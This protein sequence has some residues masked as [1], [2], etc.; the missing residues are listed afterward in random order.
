MDGA[1]AYKYGGQYY[2]KME[3]YGKIPVNRSNLVNEVDFVQFDTDVIMPKDRVKMPDGNFYRVDGH[4]LER[5]LDI[6]CHY[7]YIPLFEIND[8]EKVTRDDEYFYCDYCK[9]FENKTLYRGTFD[10][11]RMCGYAY[12]CYYG[13]CSVCGE[14]HVKDD[15]EIT[16]DGEYICEECATTQG[17]ERCPNCGNHFI[18]DSVDNNEG[19]CQRC[20]NERF[21]GTILDYCHTRAESFFDVDNDG[22]V[23]ISPCECDKPIPMYL[24]IELEV[25]NEGVLCH[26]EL[27]YR[28]LGHLNVFDSMFCETKGDSSIGG[29]FELVTQPSTPKF[30]MSKPNW[31]DAFN[32]IMKNGGLS[33]DCDTCGLHMHVNRS[34]FKDDREAMTSLTVAVSNL[35]D[36]IVKFSR[37]DISEI[38]EWCKKVNIG[39]NDKIEDIEEKYSFDRYLAVNG[40]NTH[41]I[42]FRFFKGTLIYEQFIASIQMISMLVEYVRDNSFEIVRKASWKDIFGN[43]PFA[44][45]TAVCGDLGIDWDLKSPFENE[46]LQDPVMSPQGYDFLDGVGKPLFKLGHFTNRN[47]VMHCPSEEKANIFLAILHKDGRKWP[48]IGTYET[49]NRYRFYGERTCYA[50]NKGTYAPI[51]FYSNNGCPVLEFDDFSWLEPFNIYHYDGY[52]AMRV[53]NRAEDLRFRQYLDSVGQ[54]WADGSSYLDLTYYPG[55]SD[56]VYKFNENVMSILPLCSNYTVLNFSDFLWDDIEESEDDE[57]SEYHTISF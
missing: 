23:T 33:H 47:F 44:E 10:G 50:F 17:W 46:P 28:T 4:S 24:G 3:K 38:D 45:F 22:N 2:V 39:R 14:V 11:Q 36:N 5:G 27:A 16:W 55:C 41:T 35:W 15:L 18:P 19:I 56:F 40:R 6:S 51:E 1:K 20:Y 26:D 49:D 37:R 7:S 21:E 31:K 25:K 43:C 8:H 42:E 30:H 32:M 13:T 12:A 54:E 53:S 9:C 57:P 48:D 29:G 52:F 34:Y